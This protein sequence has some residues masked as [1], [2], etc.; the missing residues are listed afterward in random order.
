MTEMEYELTKARVFLRSR[1]FSLRYRIAFRENKQLGKY[2]ALIEKGGQHTRT[3][4]KSNN[5]EDILNNFKERN[6]ITKE[7]WK[8]IK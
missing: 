2:F 6:T 3:I 8:R 7:T 1:G 4:A 5:I